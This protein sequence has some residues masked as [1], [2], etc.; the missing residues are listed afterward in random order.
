MNLFKQARVKEQNKTTACTIQSCQ[1]KRKRTEAQGESK[2]IKQVKTFFSD[3]CLIQRKKSEGLA[4][5]AR[6]Y[7]IR[8][9]TYALHLPAPF[10]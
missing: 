6:K 5:F 7:K 10:V 4:A 8:L 9:P 1:R 3:V 2:R